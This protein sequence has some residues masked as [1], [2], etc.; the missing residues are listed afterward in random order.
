MAL[1][2]GLLL[3]AAAMVLEWPVAG[4]R[5]EFARR[6]AKA[7]GFCHI[8]PQG[9]GPRNQTGIRYARAEFQ[10]PPRPG[11]LNDFKSTKQRADFVYARKLI[12]I[13]HVRAARKLLLRLDKALK[14]EPSAQKMVR[15]ELQ[16]LKVR[17]GEIL[18]QARR[19]VRK[20][21]VEEAVSLYALLLEEYR[22]FDVFKEA[23]GD[24]KEIAREK[25][26]SPIV[27]AEKN[28]AKARLAYLNARAD[29]IAGKDASKKYKKVVDRYAGTRA[30]KL[31]A[32]RLPKPSEG[33]KEGE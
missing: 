7:C 30:A 32:K 12:D 5:P 22:D 21:R 23:K 20:Q 2:T 1:R 27:K 15:D 24:L 33:A 19:L 28:E 4:A 3:L 25:E 13:D 14:K 8:N 6:E 9:G 31:A 17:S 26:N 10:F 16:G 29:E 18:G 11:N